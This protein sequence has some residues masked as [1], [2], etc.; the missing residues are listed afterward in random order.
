M[1]SSPERH[2]QVPNSGYLLDEF[3]QYSDVTSWSQWCFSASRDPSPLPDEAQHHALRLRDRL[4]GNLTL[5]NR[6]FS[7]IVAESSF[8]SAISF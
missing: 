2:N 1:D 7:S 5:R 8:V 3:R 4:F 6:R